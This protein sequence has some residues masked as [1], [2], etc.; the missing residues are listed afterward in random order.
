MKSLGTGYS[1]NVYH[2]ALIT[3]LNRAGV[4]HRSE[5]QAPIYFKREIVGTGRCDLVIGP[6]IVEI[7]ANR[8]PPTRVMP[9]LRKYAIS[10]SRAERRQYRG[11][12]INFNQKTG[13]VQTAILKK[14]KNK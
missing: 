8:Q 7:K 2:R 10:L 5:V 11:I 6:L 4:P 12:I 13:R 1:E 3:S 9:Q 14:T